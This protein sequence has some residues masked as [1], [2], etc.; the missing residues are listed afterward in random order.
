VHKRLAV[1][2]DEFLGLQFDGAA[3]AVFACVISVPAQ[4]R[5]ALEFERRGCAS[6]SDGHL[7][8]SVDGAGSVRQGTMQGELGGVA[9]AG[10]TST[11]GGTEADE[12]G[13]A[14]GWG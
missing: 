7:R 12:D 11:A 1:H 4:I 2:D 5:R 13:E 8:L 3:A 14:G 10:G 6:S 9:G